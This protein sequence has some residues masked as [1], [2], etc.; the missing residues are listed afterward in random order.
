MQMGLIRV[1]LALSVVFFHAIPQFKLPLVSATLA[2]KTFFMISGFYMSLILHKKYVGKNRAYKLFITN[3]I[4]RL[5]P[6]YW[7]VLLLT[8]LFVLISLK[9][10]VHGRLPDY[11]SRYSSLSLNN[12][13]SLTL[14]II[15]NLTLILTNNY[16]TRN[17][18][19][20]LFVPQAWTLQ[21]EFL[22][23]FL[24]PL[25]VIKNR[26]ILFLVVLLII[27]YIVFHFQL[28]NF[29]LS[30]Y[31]FFNSLTFFLMG[32]VAYLIYSKLKHQK[33]QKPVLII[34]SA[35]AICLTLFYSAV[36]FP[37][38]Y[39]R[40]IH[41]NDWIYYLGMFFS[42]PFIFILSEESVV[43]SL[44]GELS[45]PIY[46]S[47]FLVISVIQSIAPKIQET[48]FLASVLI[49]TFFF[50]VILVKFLEK[51]INKYRQKRLSK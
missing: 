17:V 47:H 50:S 12:L 15:Q 29:S 20:N 37:T 42:L 22:F 38:V 39:F 8:F 10:G 24:A 6:T 13:P 46:I 31:Q 14:D 43:D 44:L 16:F 5:M 27:N 48:V 9:L 23:Y 3:R 18:Q 41:L 28:L 34:F 49:F 21:F 35:F 40:F 4:L 30:L 1:L 25:I 33:I 32:S 26:A 2:I 19:A 51:P 45:Y 36:P 7:V 11:A